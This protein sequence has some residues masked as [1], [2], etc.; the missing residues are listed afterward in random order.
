MPVLHSVAHAQA[1]KG[2]R[3]LLTYK[4][5]A[6]AIVNSCATHSKLVIFVAGSKVDSKQATRNTYSKSKDL[7]TFKA[8]QGQARSVK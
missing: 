3:C 7:V 6:L 5:A 1:A 2:Q 4:P 8:R